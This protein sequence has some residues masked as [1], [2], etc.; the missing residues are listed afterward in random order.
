MPISLQITLVV[1]LLAVAAGLLSVCFYTGRAARSLDAFLQ[2]AHK[3]LARISDDAHASRL[4][5]DQLADSLQICLDEFAGFARTAGSLG[6]LVNELQNQFQTGLE[7]A[8]R[9][10]GSLL[11]LLGPV[12]AA[13]RSPRQHHGEEKE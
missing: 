9:S 11:G 3:D 2:E 13:L 12:L 8:S 7:T 5:M 4:R 6:R 1:V 10:L